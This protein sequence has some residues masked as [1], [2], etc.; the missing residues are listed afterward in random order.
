MWAGL[1]R[2]R[3][4]PPYLGQSSYSMIGPIEP[5][6]AAAIRRLYRSGMGRT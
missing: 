1:G 4:F 3:T 2:P 6:N 5:M